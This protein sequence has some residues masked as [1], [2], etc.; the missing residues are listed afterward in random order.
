MKMAV[1]CEVKVAPDLHAAAFGLSGLGLL[2][3]PCLCRRRWMALR[4]SLGLAQRHHFHYVVERQVEVGA[5]LADQFFFQR[6][7]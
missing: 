2:L 7:E 1:M 4:D 6:L 5:R 3:M